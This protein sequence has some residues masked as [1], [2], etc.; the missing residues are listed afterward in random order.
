MEDTS[1]WQTDME[2]NGPLEGFLAGSEWTTLVCNAAPHSTAGAWLC[3]QW[4][5]KLSVHT[6]TFALSQGSHH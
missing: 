3:Y 5:H 1:V 4:R 6:A 2:I